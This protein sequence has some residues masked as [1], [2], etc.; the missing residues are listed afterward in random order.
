MMYAFPARL[1]GPKE[2][3]GTGKDT[4]VLTL[5][6]LNLPVHLFSGVHHGAGAELYVGFDLGA[7]RLFVP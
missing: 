3:S 5:L 7:P 2:T 6:T 1:S 4:S